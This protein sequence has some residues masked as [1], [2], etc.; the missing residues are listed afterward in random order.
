[1]KTASLVEEGDEQ[2]VRLP[3]DVRL[4]GDE[5]WIKRIGDAVLLLPKS[6]SWETWL[7]SLEQF[8]DDF[9]LERDPP[10]G[11]ERPSKF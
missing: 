8:S 11:Q 4:P 10:G 5:A 9:M 7:S 6:A 1:M 2:V 3:P